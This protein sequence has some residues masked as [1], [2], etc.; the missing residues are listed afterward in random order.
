MFARVSYTFARREREYLILAHAARASYTRAPSSC[1][2]ASESPHAGGF[3]VCVGALGRFGARAR[4]GLRG[5]VSGEFARVA[6]K[7]SLHMH[8][9]RRQI[10]AA[11]G[12]HGS[13][14][15]PAGNESHQFRS[16][17]PVELHAA[18]TR[19]LDSEAWIPW[20]ADAVKSA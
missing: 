5:Q 6:I 9:K 12:Q 7:C 3:Q 4:A 13:I 1:A 15:A 11:H 8:V 14:S 20:Q 17:D 19:S 2:D 16:L 10:N 18:E